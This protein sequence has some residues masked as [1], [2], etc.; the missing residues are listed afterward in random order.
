MPAAQ[1][2][3]VG[4][5]A[6]DVVSRLDERQSPLGAKPGRQR[7]RAFREVRVAENDAVFVDER[8]PEPEILQRVGEQIPQPSSVENPGIPDALQP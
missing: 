8:G 5:D 4:D 3:Q 2:R 6:F 7:V 1:G